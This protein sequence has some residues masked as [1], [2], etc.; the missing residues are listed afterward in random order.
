MEN[1]ILDIDGKSHTVAIIGISLEQFY[2]S[3]TQSSEVLDD[4]TLPW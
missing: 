4:E 2:L 1:S 3:I